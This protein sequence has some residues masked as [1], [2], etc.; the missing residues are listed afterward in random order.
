MMVCNMV[1]LI[2]NLHHRQPKEP[3]FFEES[4]DK[5]TFV[6]WKRQQTQ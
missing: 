5:V 2:L 1:A 3:F 6:T 4:L